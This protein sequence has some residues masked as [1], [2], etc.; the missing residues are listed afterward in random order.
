[1]ER[2]PLTPPAPRKGAS[3]PGSGA[4]LDLCLRESE[5]SAFSAEEGQQALRCLHPAGPSEELA[6]GVCH[7]HKGQH[8]GVL[9]LTGEVDDLLL[10]VIAV[11]SERNK[12]LLEDRSDVR[13]RDESLNEAPA[14]A[15]QLPPKLD[16]D[17]LPP[18][19][20][21]RVGFAPLGVPGEGPLVV[22]VGM[23]SQ[24]A[25]VSRIRSQEHRIGAQS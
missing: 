12:A 5:R 14:L 8:V 25:H 19:S 11:R 13:A 16:E 21:R 4:P 10:G 1:M 20:G 6:A 3:V 24:F 18:L 15:S 17:L 22:E 9:E 7:D 2:S 23:C